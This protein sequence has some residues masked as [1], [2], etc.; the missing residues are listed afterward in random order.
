M[1]PFDA[2][3]YH[4]LLS[5]KLLFC[6]FLKGSGKTFCSGADVL[7]LYHSINEGPS[8]VL[9]SIVKYSERFC[10]VQRRSL[11]SLKLPPPELI[12]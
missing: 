12:W 9:V 8:F 5:I 3:L 11:D 7:P 10:Q 6:F 2:W 4:N 1:C